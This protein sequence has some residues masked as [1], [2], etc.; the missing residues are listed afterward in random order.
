[1]KES[2]KLIKRIKLK[3]LQKERDFPKIKRDFAFKKL[4]RRKF[5]S[6]HQCWE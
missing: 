1:M 6:P 3:F 2:F 5:Y 4:F